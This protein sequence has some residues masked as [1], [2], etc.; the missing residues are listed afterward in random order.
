MRLARVLVCIWVWAAAAD[1]QEPTIRTD[2]NLVQVNLTVTD[3]SGHPVTGL[4]RGAFEL[5]VDDV[6]QPISLFQGE[7]APVTAA[8]VIDNSASMKPKREQVIEAARAFARASNPR[9]QMFV[10][11]FNER[12]RFGLKEGTPFTGD[13]AELEAAIARF[14]LG[15]T[16]ALYDAILTATSR[17]SRA[18]NSGKVLLI[19]TDGGDNSS[20]AK[21]SDVLSAVAKYDAVVFAVGIFDPSDKD[22]NPQALTEMAKETGGAAYF[23]TELS[24]VTRICQRIAREVRR[25]Y[26]L[27][28]AGA[29][30]GKYHRIRVVA[31]DPSRGQL[32]VHTR[33]GYFAEKRQK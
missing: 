19:I 26:T 8:I 11:H 1:Q 9:D 32:D 6:P 27:G 23:P 28:F 16:T 22:S 14:Q 17:F 12:A 30:D 20:K 33:I 21:L 10:V 13:I 18:A 25:Q 15:G 29:E 24:E 31:K 7:D 5:F 2:V 3:K 4:P